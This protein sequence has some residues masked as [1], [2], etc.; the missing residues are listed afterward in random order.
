MTPFE[1]FLTAFESSSL[2]A[3]SRAIDWILADSDDSDISSADPEELAARAWIRPCRAA[4]GTPDNASRECWQSGPLS[5]AHR[6]MFD[7][8]E[9]L[10]LCAP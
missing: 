6:H 3:R 1:K 4:V 9:P 8:K 2:A 10:C 7:V 5:A